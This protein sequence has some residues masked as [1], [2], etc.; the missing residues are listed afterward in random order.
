MAEVILP[1]RGHTKTLGREA[2]K[3]RGTTRELKRVGMDESVAC[4]A[5]GS[6]GFLCL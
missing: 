1:G 5:S 3:T 6:S 2:E 4:A